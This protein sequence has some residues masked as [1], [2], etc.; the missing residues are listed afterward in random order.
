M[1]RG[2]PLP[3]FFEGFLPGSCCFIEEVWRIED[4]SD[5]EKL[6]EKLSTLAQEFEVQCKQ[7]LDEE[8]FEKELEEIQDSAETIRE[9]LQ[10]ISRVIRY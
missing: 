1:G 5:L 6:A 10:K 2:F 4:W 9:Q 8:Q 3:L 7:V